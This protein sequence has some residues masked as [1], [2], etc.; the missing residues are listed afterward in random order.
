[1]NL[2][3][4][5]LYSRQCRESRLGFFDF[6]VVLGTFFYF[7]VRA[8]LSKKLGQWRCHGQTIERPEAAVQQLPA[9]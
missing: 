8:F 5:A 4:A 2:A 9:Y 7:T 1:L 3:R 6:A